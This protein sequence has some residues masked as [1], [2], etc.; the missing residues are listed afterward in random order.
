[1]RISAKFVKI[2]KYTIGR[3]KNRRRIREVYS[4]DSERKMTLIMI[5]RY[6]YDVQPDF[7]E[8]IDNI[9]KNSL[10]K[11]YEKRP[12][13]LYKSKSRQRGRK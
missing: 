10:W 1:M 7:L 2:Y 11:F 12:Y 13:W 3:G 5:D 9:N 4:G 8:P 6:P